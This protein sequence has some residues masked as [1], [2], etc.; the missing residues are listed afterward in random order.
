MIVDRDVSSISEKNNDIVEV[1]HKQDKTVYK[2]NK[3]IVNKGTSFMKP[4][5]A[6]NVTIDVYSYLSIKNKDSI[7]DSKLYCINNLCLENKEFN[8]E[9]NVLIKIMNSIIVSMRK[10]EVCKFKINYDMLGKLFDFN[11]IN[12]EFTL[13]EIDNKNLLVDY[14]NI[15]HLVDSY[16]N[17]NYDNN[18]V[19]LNTNSSTIL[20]NKRN[21]IELYFIVKLNNYYISHKLLLNGDLKKKIINSDF[22]YNQDPEQEESINNN[23]NKCNIKEEDYINYNVII[24]ADEEIIKESLNNK[25]FVEDISPISKSS[26]K[27]DNSV[28][29][30]LFNNF[31]A[32]EKILLL[33]MI[34][35]E[36]SE[37]YI[38]SKYFNN[39]FPDIVQQ[40]PVLKDK[41]ITVKIKINSVIR[42]NNIFRN[43]KHYGKE[44]K[45]TILQ[46]GIG[47]DSP[48]RESYVK[49][50]L[51]LRINNIIIYN[52]F[53]YINNLIANNQNNL[54]LNDLNN[55][56]NKEESSYYINFRNEQNKI[57][58]N[59]SNDNIDNKSNYNTN[60]AIFD[61]LDKKAINSNSELFTVDMKLYSIPLSLRKV[62]VHMK[63]NEICLINTNFIDNFTIYDY[64]DTLNSNSIDIKPLIDIQNLENAN[65]QIIIHLFE[66]VERPIFSNLSYVEKLEELSSKKTKAVFLFKD[67]KYYQASK[68]FNNCLYRLNTGDVF[69]NSSQIKSDNLYVNNFDMYNTLHDLKIALTLNLVNCY[70]KLNKYKKAY[71]I[72]DDFMNYKFNSKDYFENNNFKKNSINIQYNKESSV[73]N[74]IICINNYIEYIISQ[75]NINNNIE[76]CNKLSQDLYFRIDKTFKG[77]ILYC[78]ILNYLKDIEGLKISCDIIK[79]C[80]DLIDKIIKNSDIVLKYCNKYYLD[81]NGINLI[82]QMQQTFNNLL[83]E[84]QDLLNLNQNKQKNMF[85]KM[86]INNN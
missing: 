78:T 54:E 28:N 33:T 40:H 26:L 56:I 63:R 52:S 79:R 38:E 14:T 77:C 67:S 61:K 17:N 71:F 44:N 57:Y 64:N 13:S 59:E 82:N 31:N 43:I 21:L 53:D 3:T 70:I 72:I 46:N 62:I 34:P 48:D 49:F 6:D 39:A 60:K 15:E 9:E 11:D 30:N 2:L 37:F 80:L 35:N 74:H 18:K 19:V 25:T 7:N 12:N 27:R 68:I 75:D 69:G 29:P 81:L 36:E 41:F 24:Y 45:Y 1:K 10:K 83:K 23:N 84:S 42:Y 16:N 55:F 86:F 66:F 58:N 85:K 22:F 73:F 47:L 20:N 76:E 4:G 5:N 32:I 51:M 50:K 65:I 8:L